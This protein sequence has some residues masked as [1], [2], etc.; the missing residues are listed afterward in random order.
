MLDSLL[1]VPLLIFN[2]RFFESLLKIRHD[3][4][5]GND[6]VNDDDVSDDDDDHNDDDVA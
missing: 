2:D 5:D 4:D 1:I 6:N 3:D